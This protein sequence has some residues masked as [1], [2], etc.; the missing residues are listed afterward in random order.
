MKVIVG[1]KLKKTF[2]K[3]KMIK[4]LADN[5]H[6]TQIIALLAQFSECL[7]EINDVLKN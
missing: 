5:V 6:M 2:V 7:E 1:K 3:N 4:G